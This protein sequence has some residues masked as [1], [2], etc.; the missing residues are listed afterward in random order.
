MFATKFSQKEAKQLQN[1]CHCHTNKII[2]GALM[3]TF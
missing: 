1:I 3:V 2:D